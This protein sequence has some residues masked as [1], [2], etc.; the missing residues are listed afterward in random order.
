MIFEKHK[1]DYMPGSRSGNSTMVKLRTIR[2]L[3]LRY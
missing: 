2:W 3:S 1:L